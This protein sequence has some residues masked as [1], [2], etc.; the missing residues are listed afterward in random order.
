[1]LPSNNTASK[2][3]LSVQKKKKNLLEFK[4]I[5]RILGNDFCLFGNYI[6]FSLIFGNF[7]WV[8]ELFQI[9]TLF[10]QWKYLYK[11]WFDEYPIFTTP[12]STTRTIQKA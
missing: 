10:R 6:Y 4:F 1:M 11:V 2:D 12:E 3:I 8:E 5:M 7:S 9:D